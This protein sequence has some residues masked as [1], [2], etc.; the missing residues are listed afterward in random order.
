MADDD[1]LITNDIRIPRA[2]LEYR[3]VRSRGPGGQNVN[4]VSTQ[5]ELLFDVAGSPS[6]PEDRRA[7]VRERLA[8]LI[9]SRG[10]LHLASQETRS[11]WRN[12]EDVTA[13]FV[14]LLRGALRERKARRPT[15]P[16]AAARERRLESKRRRADVK[17]GRSGGGDW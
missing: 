16:T 1:L 15:R 6:L 11:Q 4:R 7:R 2:E 14:D 13:R 5:V 10:V 3:F 12:R 17:R 9:D 8:N